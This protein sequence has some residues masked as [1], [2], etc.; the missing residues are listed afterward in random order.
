MQ[1]QA[2]VQSCTRLRCGNSGR[3]H[4]SRPGESPPRDQRSRVGPAKASHASVADRVQYLEKLLGDSVDAHSSELQALKAEHAKHADAVAKQARD[5][6]GQDVHH[7]AMRERMAYLE[8]LLGDSADKHAAELNSLKATFGVSGGS[9]PCTLNRSMTK[10]SLG[11]RRTLAGRTATTRGGSRGRSGRTD[12][13][14][15][16]GRH[17][18]ARLP[19]RGARGHRVAG[20]GPLR[21][22]TRP[23]AR[24]RRACLGRTAPEAH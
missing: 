22:T 8:K 14:R 1:T 11:R 5:L 21:R 19:L 10:V 15:C 3:V 20:A 18:R 7:A 2:S 12:A 4:A 23:P 13:S 9:A 17:L 6:Q 24:H 16:E